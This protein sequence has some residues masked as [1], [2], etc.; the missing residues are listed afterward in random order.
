VAAL[1]RW[2]LKTGAVLLLIGG[3][4]KGAS[5]LPQSGKIPGDLNWQ[6]GKLPL[7][8]PLGT[9]AIVVLLLTAYVNI[10]GDRR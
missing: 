2:F 10:V 5:R 4:L 3:A 9:G 1:T 6:M 7:R 8:L